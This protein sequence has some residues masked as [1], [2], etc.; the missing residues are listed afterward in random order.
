MLVYNSS[1][2]LTT[3]AELPT[4]YTSTTALNGICSYCSKSRPIHNKK[5]CRRDSKILVCGQAWHSVDML[6]DV[7]SS[8]F[9]TEGSHDVI[10][11]RHIHGYL[12]RTDKHVDKNTKSQSE[13]CTS[14]LF[15]DGLPEQCLKYDCANHALLDQDL[16]ICA[17]PTRSTNWAAF[18]IM[19]DITL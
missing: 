4:A 7:D 5:N 14:K 1:S 11:R 3:V 17:S 9:D 10:S 13:I 2:A 18:D 12:S 19:Q 8:G 6:C 16:T 15:H